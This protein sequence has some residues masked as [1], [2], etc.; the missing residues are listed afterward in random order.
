MRQPALPSAAIPSPGSVP[1]RLMLAPL[2]ALAVASPLS[3]GSG[4]LDPSF[5]TG[6]VLVEQ[7]PTEGTAFSAA[8]VSS[9]G[10]SLALAVGR[11]AAVGD[12]PEILHL[13]FRNRET[14]QLIYEVATTQEFEY[15]VRHVPRIR[16]SPNGELWVGLSSWRTDY[17]FGILRFSSTG[18]YLGET[19]SDFASV[20]TAPRHDHLRDLAFLSDGRAVAVGVTY[21]VSGG[22]GDFAVAMYE[23]DGSPSHSAR[24]NIDFGGDLDDLAYAVAVDSQDRILVGGYSDVATGVQFMS[25][26]RL[27]DDTTPDSS[28]GLA[29]VSLF[30]Y[31][32]CDGCAAANPTEVVDLLTVGDAVYVLGAAR[33]A[34]GG[35]PDVVVGRLTPSGLP[36]RSF[37][38]WGW[39]RIASPAFDEAVAFAL[40]PGNQRIVVVS[41]RHVVPERTSVARITLG[42]QL[43][44]TFGTGG[45][46]YLDLHPGADLEAVEGLAIEGLDAQ[47]KVGGVALVGYVAIDPPAGDTNHDVVIARLSGDTGELGRDD[48][49]SGNASAWSVV[50]P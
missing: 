14:G 8:F 43:D 9:F 16:Q 1:L 32:A 28:F 29:G 26:A 10:G 13:Q 11:G 30:S 36:D 25:V 38:T 47:G 50:Q 37:G 23:P 7:L 34:G 39:A 49:E 12:D 33:D 48:F 19:W 41:T 17:D 15:P 6:G 45:V 18:V 20:P 35:L 21:P 4:D 40:D 44:A 2:L 42:G 24:R 3:A 27:L 46:T 22:S 31:E 5:G